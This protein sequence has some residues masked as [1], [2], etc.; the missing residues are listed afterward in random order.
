MYLVE[1]RGDR[2]QEEKEQPACAVSQRVYAKAGASVGPLPPGAL[3][4]S[5]E[6]AYKMQSLKC[7]ALWDFRKNKKLDP[8]G[9][10]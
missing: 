2:P 4:F 7:T 6:L 8:V 9:W 10:E 1:G 3:T 5:W